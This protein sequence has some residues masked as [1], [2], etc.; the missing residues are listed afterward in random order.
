MCVYRMD[1][2]EVEAHRHV[3]KRTSSHLLRLFSHYECKRKLA[4]FTDGSHG[5]V[6]ISYQFT[7]FLFYKNVIYENIGAEICEILRIFGQ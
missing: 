3:K 4:M 7:L 6:C 1:Q 5:M 2:D